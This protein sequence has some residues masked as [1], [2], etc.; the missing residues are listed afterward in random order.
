MGKWL[1]DA[2]VRDLKLPERGVAKVYDAAD[3]RGKLGW[4][5][6][7]GVRAYAG[8]A[9]TFVLLYRSRKTRAEHLYTIGSFPDWSVPA[10]RA[11]A[12]ELKRRIDLGGD[13]QAERK[14]ARDAATVADLCD[15]FLT[16]YVVRKQPNTRRDYTGIVETIIKPALGRKMV[17]AVDHA[18]IEKLHREITERASH[19]ANRTVAVL[20]RMMTLAIK[21]RMR[22]DNPV[23]G[24]ER[25]PEGKRKRYLKGDELRLLTKALAEHEDQRVANVFRLL[26]LTGARKGEVL[27]A[28]WDQFD[29]GGN[30][31]TKPAATTKQ[32]QE[33][34]IP[35]SPVALQLLE[36]MRK[37][38]APTARFLFP[39]HGTTGHLTEVKKAWAAV[40]RAGGIVGLRV[41]DLRHSYASML[42][43]AGYSLP[44]IGALLGHTQPNTTHRYAHLLDDPLR[45]A[46]SKVGAL[47]SGLVA[48]QPAKGKRLKVVAGGGR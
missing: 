2:Y 14:A 1:T 24:V 17:T 28:T 46:T 26:L 38:S 11:E 33:H 6:G 20:S 25:N 42:A 27:S 21:W 37:T 18:D 22:A 41:H 15:R 4:T 13:P 43:S 12:R 48:K 23:R 35:L 40:C 9:K 34:E 45:E 39:S 36:T 10:A 30:V 32:R 3:P 5:T 19:R 29:F 7:F 31:W 47:M 16:E 8:G 44:T